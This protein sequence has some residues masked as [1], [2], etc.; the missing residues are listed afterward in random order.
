M[1]DS[2]VRVTVF[3]VSGFYL[4]SVIVGIELPIALAAKNSQ[5]KI[6]LPDMEWEIQ[7]GERIADIA[8]LIYP[9]DPISRDRLIRAIIEGNPNV[10]P[11]GIDEPV[12]AGIV[13]IIP[14]LRKV[15]A[16][17][18][19]PE[20]NTVQSGSSDVSKARRTVMKSEVSGD[21]STVSD[22]LPQLIDHLQQEDEKQTQGINVLLARIDQLETEV[23]KLMDRIGPQNATRSQTDTTGLE[24]K[25]SL[26]VPVAQL[27]APLP[28]PLPV[29]PVVTPEADEIS[30]Q[31]ILDLYLLPVSGGFLVILLLVAGMRNYRKKRD[32]A[33]QMD[34]EAIELV[35]PVIETVKTK[36]HE[37][38]DVFPEEQKVQVIQKPA[39]KPVDKNERMDDLV[40]IDARLFVKQGHPDVAVQFLISQLAAN[41]KVEKDWLLLF[42][43]LHS[44]NNKT[45]FKKH[46]RRFKRLGFFPDTWAQIQS[47]GHALEPMEPLYF[48]EKERTEKFFSS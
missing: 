39:A 35:K 2:I 4:S 26:P 40:L 28:T 32:Q 3:V 34:D 13:I 25:N 5:Q 44:Q 20:G 19:I 33:N 6:S 17:I 1:F 38:I 42:E 10:F 7:S 48:T 22:Q 15:N 37:E 16:T 30:L 12:A 11:K 21:K 47:W 18:A 36:D 24:E 9:G 41:N 27:S 23:T 45:E 8:R 46:A 29:T 14:D 31:T 43:I